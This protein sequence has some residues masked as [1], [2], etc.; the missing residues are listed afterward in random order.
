MQSS[1]WYSVNSVDLNL[2]TNIILRWVVGLWWLVK[3]N[4]WKRKITIW[5]SYVFCKGSSEPWSTGHG[6]ELFWKWR[7]SFG[8][9][10][11][12]K[13]E[14]PDI[15]AKG[16]P[17]SDLY[18]Q[19]VER[20]RNTEKLKELIRIKTEVKFSQK[21]HTAPSQ[22]EKDIESLRNKKIQEMEELLEIKN[23]KERSRNELEEL[24]LDVY[25]EK[26]LLDSLRHQRAS[27]E[28]SLEHRRTV[29]AARAA[30]RCNLT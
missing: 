12:L 13:E 7:F 18:L 10:H 17:L 25:R 8:H 4:I 6:L 26:N 23:K 14:N 20:E 19:A 30:S 27:K 22:V 3:W 9:Q 5:E 1:S 15:S 24:R 29:E 28:A 11:L 2:M 16:R 21:I